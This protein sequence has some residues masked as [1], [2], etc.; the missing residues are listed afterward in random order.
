MPNCVDVCLHA[1]IT[2]NIVSPP[3]LSVCMLTSYSDVIVL[4]SQTDTT[5]I[6]QLDIN[7]DCSAQRD[8]SG[9][10]NFTSETPRFSPSYTVHTPG[11]MTSISSLL[12]GNLVS[13]NLYVLS[14]SKALLHHSRPSHKSSKNSRSTSTQR[15]APRGLV[16]W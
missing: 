3:W 4:T 14:Q 13:P 9:F 2:A 1:D 15:L 16:C 8:R 5:G 12:G 10:S 11:H 6:A 7:G